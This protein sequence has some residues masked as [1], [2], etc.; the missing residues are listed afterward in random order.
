[1]GFICWNQAIFSGE[2][3]RLQRLYD[4]FDKCRYPTLNFTNYYTLFETDY[5]S[6]PD[7]KWG[8]EYFRPYCD[9]K[10]GVVTVLGESDW[11]PPEGLFWELCKE[12][13]VRCEYDY[14][15]I[16]YNFGGKII[17]DEEGNRLV[18]Y[19]MPYWEKLL[20]E[21]EN[22]FWYEISCRCEN[23]ELYE[24]LIAD[25]HFNKWKDISRL[26]TGRLYRVWDNYLQRKLDQYL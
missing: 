5:V 22:K 21:D 4:K 9:Y 3:D 11:C 20:I 6:F 1:M 15:Q 13:K 24:S 7:S 23:Y 18:Y 12:Y 10:N 8:S 26:D 2:P 19:E 25:M 17:W 14:G 16:E